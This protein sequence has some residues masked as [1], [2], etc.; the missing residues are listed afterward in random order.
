ML[1]VIET[2]ENQEKRLRSLMPILIRAG[3]RKPEVPARKA[4]WL[5]SSATDGRTGL[6]V[7]V[8]SNFAFLIGFM[9]EGLRS[10]LHIPARKV[11]LNI[12]IMPSAFEPLE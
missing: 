9:R 7:E 6:E 2:F 10:L 5:A 4:L 11:E 3:G 12:K 8:G 1:T